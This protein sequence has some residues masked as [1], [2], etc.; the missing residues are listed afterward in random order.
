M[1]LRERTKEQSNRCQAQ[2]ASKKS[3]LFGDIPA[4][5]QLELNVSKWAQLVPAIRRSY[6]SEKMYTESRVFFCITIDNL[7]GV[8]FTL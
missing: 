1:H 2:A 6:T 4:T 7:T 3:W 5:G 8:Y